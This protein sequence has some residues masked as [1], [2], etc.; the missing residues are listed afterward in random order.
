MRYFTIL[1]FLLNFAFSFTFSFAFGFAKKPSWEQMCVRSK[2]V[3]HEFKN[4]CAD[5]C[6]HS[7]SYACSMAFV[8]S[9]DCGAGRCWDDIEM[10]CLKRDE[11]PEI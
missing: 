1:L 4:G 5:V 6:P 2:G 3:V 7:Q 10:K 9:C 8:K 11:E